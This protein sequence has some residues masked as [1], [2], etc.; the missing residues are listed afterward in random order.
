MIDFIN[1]LY[2]MNEMNN[3]MGK[4]YVEDVRHIVVDLLNAGAKVAAEEVKKALEEK[5]KTEADD[6]ANEHRT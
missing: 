2:T 5:S 6:A 4:R 3:N 1:W